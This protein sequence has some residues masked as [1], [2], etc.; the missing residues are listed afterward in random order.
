M[1]KWASNALG[2]LKDLIKRVNK[3]SPSYK[4]VK[5]GT[6]IGIA[7]TWI[8][9]ST[10]IGM[11]IAL[12]IMTEW[13]VQIEEG[14]ILTYI[15]KDPHWGT[16]IAPMIKVYLWNLENPQEFA[17]GSK[18]MMREVGPFVYKVFVN[19]EI[20]SISDD[21]ETFTYYVKPWFEFIPE[22]TTADYDQKITMVNMFTYTAAG[23]VQNII[24][25]IPMGFFISRNVHATLESFFR[26]H[27][28]GLIMETTPRKLIEGTKINMLETID[29]VFI[30]PLRWMGK[31]SPM[32][33]KGLQLWDHHLPGNRFGFASVVDNKKIGPIVA[34]TG[35]S[36]ARLIGKV[37]SFM[38][39]MW[40]VHNL[41]EEPRCRMI[42]G[43]QVWSLSLYIKLLIEIRL[44]IIM[45]I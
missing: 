9:L 42:N 10:I 18:P 33:K 40:H 11:P 13:Q 22:R 12:K 19:H 16:S 4:R 26:A 25:R 29:K 7:M 43:S 28:Q 21:G 39:N 34:L 44:Y 20:E 14:N 38:E 36:G 1:C 23:L 35:K 2:N 8:G 17:N 30:K 31:Q 45:L 24:D 41:I 3:D 32:M 5:W 37:I 6:I 27:G 15:W